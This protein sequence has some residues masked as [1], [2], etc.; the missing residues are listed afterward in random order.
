MDVRRETPDRHGSVEGINR[1]EMEEFWTPSGE[2]TWG[3]SLVVQSV[4]V[5]PGLRITGP[6]G[7]FQ[8]Y[9][10]ENVHAPSD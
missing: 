5:Q 6:P 10:I 8:D 4:R 1:L 7:K 9:A 2:R 3:V